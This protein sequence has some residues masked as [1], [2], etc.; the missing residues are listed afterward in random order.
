MT[1]DADTIAKK[2]RKAK[3]DPEPLPDNMDDL[4]GRPEARNLINIYA[5]IS[6]QTPTEVL[7]EV[8]GQQFG[9]FKPLLADLAVAHLAP[10]AD[11]MSRLMND[12]S[13]IDRILGDGANR[14]AEIAE[15]I[16]GETF[17]IMGMIRSR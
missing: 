15:P 16:L 7:S 10:I 6:G 17:D 14:A 9:Q 8:A 13:E 5:G 11:E 4:S 1:D 3:T 2:I 12:V